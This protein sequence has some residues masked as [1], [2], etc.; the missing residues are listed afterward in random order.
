M[1]CLVEVATRGV[2]L[3][4]YWTLIP[5]ANYKKERV[6]ST[7]SVQEQEMTENGTVPSSAVPPSSNGTAEPVP[8]SSSGGC[9][10]LYW[11]PCLRSPVSSDQKSWMRRPVSPGLAS[12][13]DARPPGDDAAQ[14][15]CDG[16]GEE[17]RGVEESGDVE[18]VLVI[19]RQGPG[20]RGQ[21]GPRRAGAEHAG[22]VERGTVRQ[23]RQGGHGVQFGSFRSEIR[24]NFIVS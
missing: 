3:P 6:N 5:S 19:G 7:F 12:G 22:D 18:V 17:R 15:S 4:V 10:S 23:A 9:S 14:A 21:R 13:S 2:H 1:A 16:R 11:L 24:G 8:G 20:T